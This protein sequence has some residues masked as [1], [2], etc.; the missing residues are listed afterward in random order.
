M[1]QTAGFD[2]AAQG[3]QV[4]EVVVNIDH[5]I[6]RHFSENLYG[7]PNKAIEE[8]VSNAFDAFATKVYVARLN[9]RSAMPFRSSLRTHWA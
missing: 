9:D 4:D 8:L 6:I 5:A 3:Q 1:S 7:S 2:V